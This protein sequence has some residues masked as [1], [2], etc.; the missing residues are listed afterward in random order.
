MRKFLNYLK[1]CRQVFLVE[2]VEK[3]VKSHCH[4]LSGL[5]DLAKLA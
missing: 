4:S 5:I 2:K 3:S 1:L